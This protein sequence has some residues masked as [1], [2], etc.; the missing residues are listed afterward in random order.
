VLFEVGRAGQIDQQLQRLTGDAVLA[1]VDVEVADRDGEVAAAVGI[2]GEELTEVG[3]SDLIVMPAQGFPRRSGG[4]V[5]DRLHGGHG[6][7]LMRCCGTS[8]V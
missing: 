6:S 7:T 4:D 1:V 8:Q 5:G 2:V 3:L